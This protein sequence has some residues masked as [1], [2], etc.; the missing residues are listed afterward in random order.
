MTEYLQIQGNGEIAL[1]RSICRKAKLHKGDLLEAIVEDDG[2]IRLVPKTTAE[3]KLVEQ[4]Q[5]NDIRWSSE[6][7]K[8]TTK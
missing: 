8:K 1:P 3:R 6:G 5:L 7:K 4:F 2:S